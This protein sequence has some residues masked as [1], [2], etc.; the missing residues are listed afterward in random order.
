MKTILKKLNC[1][2]HEIIQR[3]V[4][5]GD[6]FVYESASRKLRLH[7]DKSHVQNPFR[8]GGD[9]WDFRGLKYL[10]EEIE[11]PWYEDP[12]AVDKP[13]I[14]WND[15]N[16]PP[17]YSGFYYYHTSGLFQSRENVTYK[18]ARPITAD[19]LYKEDV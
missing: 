4:N 13:C 17:V 14:F 16:A 2:S 9:P 18:H 7:Y 5:S 12:D 6:E 3:M 11:Q 15:D 10:H 1:D 19:D 8:L